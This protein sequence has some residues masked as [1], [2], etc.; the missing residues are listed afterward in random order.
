MNTSPTPRALIICLFAALFGTVL[1]L[2]PASASVT[3]DDSVISIEEP[4]AALLNTDASPGISVFSASQCPSG[5]FCVW[6]DED[7]LGSMKRYTTQAQYLTLNAGAIR[8]FYNNRSTRVFL[9]SDSSATN[10]ACYG[11][12]AKRSAT[13]GW[14]RS[15]KGAYLSTATS[16]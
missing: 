13:S 5:S 1:T 10:S 12:Q 6:S 7:Y 16:C 15:A 9:Y 4:S 8:S 11:A 3:P 14:L 2:A